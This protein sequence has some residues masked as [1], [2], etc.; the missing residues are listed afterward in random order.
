[1]QPHTK[2][3]F[4][5]FRGVTDLSDFAMFFYKIFPPVP[6]HRQAAVLIPSLAREVTLS[7]SLLCDPKLPNLV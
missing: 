1:M 2:T 3:T 7:A 5:F 6:Y 4:L